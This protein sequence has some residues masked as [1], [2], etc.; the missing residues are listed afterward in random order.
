MA[1]YDLLIRGGMIVDGKGGA[2]YRGDLAIQGQYI[3][4]LGDLSADTATQV[5]EADGQAITPGFINMLSWSVES[6]LHDGRSQSEIRQGVTLEVMGEGF[7]FGPLSEAMKAEGTRG[8]L[9]NYDLQYAIEWTTLGEY[10]EH[11]VKRGVSCNVASFA[12]SATLRIHTMGN[13]DREPSADELKAMQALLRQAMDEG[14]MG[15]STALIYPPASYSTTEELF[16]LASV[17][18]EYGGLY[19]SH[20]RGEGMGLIESLHEFIEVVEDSR[21]RG[22]IYHLKAAGRENWPLMDEA[23]AYLEESRAKGLP[24]T[25]NMYPYPYSGTGLSSCVPPWA[26]DGGEEALRERLRSPETRNIIRQEITGALNR[27]EDEKNTW[28]NMYRENGPENI[29]LCGFRNAA[30]KPLQGK[31]LAQVAAERG[32]DPIDT[33]MDLLIEDESR[34]FCLYFSMSEDNLRKQI[35]LPWVSIC[36][37]AESMAPE[38][39][40]LKSLPHP[41]AYGSFARVLAKYVRDEQIIPLEE[42]VRKMTSLPATNLRIEGRGALEPGYYADVLV[43]DPAQIQDHATPENP[44]QYATGMNHVFVNGVQVLR[45]GEHT[46]AK[47]GQVVRGPGYQRRPFEYDYPITLH[48]LLQLG[49]PDKLSTVLPHMSPLNKIGKEHLPDLIRMVKDTRLGFLDMERPEVYAPLHA[50][51]EVARLGS[52][53]DLAHLGILFDFADAEMTRKLVTFFMAL[54]IRGIPLLTEIFTDRYRIPFVRLAAMTCLRRLL[55]T[56]I[57]LIWGTVIETLFAEQL[58]GYEQ[59]APMISVLSARFLT[60]SGNPEY[61]PL[62]NKVR[63]QFFKMGQ[64]KVWE[65]TVEGVG[66]AADDEDDDSFDG[67]DLSID[68]ESDYLPPSTSFFGPP[69]SQQKGASKKKIEAAAKKKKAK[70]KAAKKR[71]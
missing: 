49:D 70:R 39:A 24:I 8:I 7:S 4:A 52:A 30:L 51:V 40:F 9:G 34:I 6:L 3:A 45:G 46:G 69:S 36:S 12:G 19:I 23:I 43:F 59:D 27:Y 15:L 64:R 28:E 71:R 50:A 35:A 14:A 1:H 55:D 32:A 48:P 17:I 26:H 68:D 47:P 65:E 16:D 67:E 25:A 5:I 10:L 2:P 13:E 58:K 37:D 20:I 60:E 22:E 61:Q 42:A 11:L 31:T 66:R 21:V 57:D 62:I 29:L 33:M 44:H 18:S 56:D 38:G 54:G 53:A 63:K 41:R